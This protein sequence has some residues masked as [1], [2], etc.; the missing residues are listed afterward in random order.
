M[1]LILLSTSKAGSEKVNDLLLCLF[2][3]TVYWHV[4]MKFLHV[5]VHPYMCYIMNEI[6]LPYLYIHIF[7]MGFPVRLD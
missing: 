3:T 2:H 4:L 5:H 6:L 7:A 1:L